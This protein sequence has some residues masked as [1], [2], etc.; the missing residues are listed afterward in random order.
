MPDGTHEVLAL[1]AMLIFVCAIVLTKSVGKNEY[2]IEHAPR[3]AARFSS[4]PRSFEV[5]E[6]TY[7]PSR[8]TLELQ[9]DH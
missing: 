6:A 4:I 7:T 8:T 3:A 9:V 2:Y 5:F 1:L